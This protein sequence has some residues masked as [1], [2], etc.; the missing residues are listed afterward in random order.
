MVSANTDKVVLVTGAAR[1]IGA[2]IARAFHARGFRVII[3]H[4]Q[5]SEAAESL[6]HEFNSFRNESAKV[7]RADLCDTSQLD[8]LLAAIKDSFNR[9]DVLVNNA[10]SFI[11]TETKTTDLDKFDEIIKLN[12]RAPY[13][14][15]QSLAERLQRSR[16]AIVNITDL[17]AKFPA[18]GYAVHCASKAGLESLT[19]SLAL[20]LAP[21]VRV[22]AIAPGAIL[23]VDGHPENSELV[24]RT[25]LKRVGTG[26]EI[27]NAA[28]F[29]ACDATFMTGQILTI[30]GGRSIVEP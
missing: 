28:V 27:A 6:E 20:E 21:D 3:H 18:V 2:Y 5:S 30:D 26:N 25:P 7:F 15:A 1:R 8:T 14:L 13:Y 16:G 4:N 17:Y 24:Q 9:I 29:L 10:A 23:W 19:R 22:N 11:S 12:L